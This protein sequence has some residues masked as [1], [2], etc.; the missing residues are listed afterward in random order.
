[1]DEAQAVRGWDL[2]LAEGKVYSHL[3]HAWDKN[4]IRVNTKNPVSLNQWHHVFVT[5]DGSSK[6]AGVTIYVDGKPAPLDRTHD[7]LTGTIRTDRPLVIGRRSANAPFKGNI[8][9]VRLYSRALSAGEVEQLAQLDPVRQILATP[10]EQRTGE[11]KERLASYYLT[12]RDEPYRRLA[13]EKAG[14]TKKRTE[15]DQAIPTTMVMQELEKPRETHV[16]IRGQYD[17]KGEK[18][19]PGT[20]EVLPPLPAAVPPN[21]LAFARWLVEPSHP[22]TARVAVNRLWQAFFG[23]GLVPTSE[24]FGTQGE[25]PSHPELLDWL[26][27]VFSSPAASNEIDRERERGSDRGSSGSLLPSASPSLHRGLN[28]DVKAMVRLIVT[29]D[30]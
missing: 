22:L 7:A 26:A 10:S 4:V 17:K 3:I 24:N 29:W 15:L 2:Y 19:S 5:Y 12:T 30:A 18:V 23:A 20:P 1:M 9:E 27:S 8:D 25:R 11:Q 6:A 21:R 28:W 14:W 16:L 13:A